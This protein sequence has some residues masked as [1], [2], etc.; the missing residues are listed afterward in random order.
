MKAKSP[1]PF[2]KCE[3]K[4]EKKAFKNTNKSVKPVAK[5]TNATRRKDTLEPL[6]NK[7]KPKSFKKKATAEPKNIK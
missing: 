7:I 5:D 6:K 2:N 1:N 4:N 3:V